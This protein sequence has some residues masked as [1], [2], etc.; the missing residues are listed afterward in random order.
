[1]KKFLVLIMGLGLIW[2]CAVKMVVREERVPKPAMEAKPDVAIKQIWPTEEERKDKEREEEIQ[3][4][5]EELNRQ[6][7]EFERETERKRLWGLSSI[8]EREKQESKIKADLPKAEVPATLPAKDLPKIAVW[9]LTAGNIP[10][11]H[12]QDLTSILVS[13]ITKLKKFEVYSQENVRTL[14]GWTAERMKLGCT[15]TQCLI[16][17]GQM[18][19]AKLISG[20]VGR[21]GNTYSI[22]LNFF[23]TQNARA[24]NAISEFCRSEDELIELIQLA[25]RKLLGEPLE[26]PTLAK[27]EKPTSAAKPVEYKDSVAGM[28]FIFV[29]GGC[30]EMGDTFGDGLYKEK[31]VHEVCVSDFYLGKYEVT[32]GQWK[33]VMGSNPSILKSSD[34]HPVENVNWNDVQEFIR[35]LNQTSGKNYR[36][37]AEAEW[38]YAARSGG[39]KEKWAGTSNE[40]ELGEYA[41]YTANSGSQTHPVGQKKPNGLG[42]YDMSGNVWEWVND[43]YDE[44]YYK[45]SPKNNPRGPDRGSERVLHGGSWRGSP[46][47]VRA[48]FRFRGNPASRDEGIGFRLGIPGQ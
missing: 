21:I 33:K 28:E 48:A 7:E 23:D 8:K 16:A 45:T 12:A 4:K 29:K 10:P 41:W 5:K 30:Y 9:D 19:I 38:E 31:P 43:W 18:D 20:R 42:F 34:D 39:K 2:G 27:A 35:R 13:E 15:D 46:G 25:V 40:S 22:S 47:T 11:T 37:P 3:R 14:A 24:V 32:Q 6:R 44:N 26:V 1:M 36:L 17:L